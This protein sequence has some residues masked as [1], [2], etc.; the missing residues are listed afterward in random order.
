MWQRKLL[1]GNEAVALSALDHG[2]S[3]GTGYPG[4]PSTEILEAIATFEQTLDCGSMRVQWAPNE[5]VAFEV[6]IGAAFAGARAMVTMKH[7]GV[8]VAADALFSAAYTTVPGALV[9]ICGDDPGMASSQNE[10]DSRRYA[11]AA[12]VPVLEPTDSQQAYDYLAVATKIAERWQIPV[13]LRMTTR[14]CHS[15]TVVEPKRHD[16]P[17]ALPHYSRDFSGR[18]MLPGNARRAH[19]LLRTKLEEIAAW[20]DDS[21]LIQ[22]VPGSSGLGVVCS[23]VTA[24]H[25]R[26][27][28]PGVSILAVGMCHPLPLERI[29]EFAQSVERCI[30]L[31]EGDPVLFEQICAAG[32]VLSRPPQEFRFGEMNVQRVRQLLTG[33]SPEVPNGPPPKPPE[34]CKGCSHRH[35]FSVLSKHGLLV[36]GDIGCYTLAA[37]PPLSAI[38][39]VVCMGA[40]IGVGLGLRHA[41]GEKEGRKVV[42][43]IGDST[44]VHSGITGLVEMVYNPPESGHVVIVV[45]N[46]TTAMTGQQE[47]PGTGRNLRRSPTSRLSIEGVASAIGV[48]RV[49]V[50]DPVAENNRFERTLLEMLGSGKCCVIVARR[51]CLLASKASHRAAN[52]TAVSHITVGQC[53]QESE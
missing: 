35:V 7:V 38:D 23:G 44:F 34:L 37:L 52:R 25:V 27:A 53:H 16:I 48:D 4:T 22:R 19:R 2:F 50:I 3:L 8:N 49:E 17:A 6:G 9:L 11:V 39:S 45:D 51:A 24:M 28:A 29:R 33:Q 10:Q 32:I 12:G 1:S 15:K 31:E 43:V 30:V 18:V 20:A 42:S 47:H 21:D 13:L 46:G 26:E 5:K 40:S 36:S 14:V 41:L